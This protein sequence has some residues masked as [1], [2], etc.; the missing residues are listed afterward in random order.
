MVATEI[1]V[2]D[3]VFKIKSLTR[4]A[5]ERNEPLAAPPPPRSRRPGTTVFEHPIGLL[6]ASSD[7]PL[8]YFTPEELAILGGYTP[9]EQELFA[10]RGA[11]IK[12][13]RFE[14]EGRLTDLTT[15]D[16]ALCIIEK[17]MDV[18][19]DIRH[20]P[21]G[22]RARTVD[23]FEQIAEWIASDVYSEVQYLFLHG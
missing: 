23:E 4:P 1:I 12:W 11:S 13:A 17:A 22:P 6:P 2:G 9:A 5:R 14:A 8:P 3:K 10:L 16:V 19:R 18:A 7:W 20:V 21:Y 15:D